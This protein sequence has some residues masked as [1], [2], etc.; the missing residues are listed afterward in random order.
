MF[1]IDTSSDDE[2]A[3]VQAAVAAYQNRTRVPADSDSGSDSAS[4]S[5]DETPWW[6]GLSN[7]QITEIAEGARFSSHTTCTEWE[8]AEGEV[9][10]E[11]RAFVYH[12]DQ[13]ITVVAHIHPASNMVF[14][15]TPGH[16]YIVGL[17]NWECE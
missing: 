10:R 13:Q 7:E 3:F 11:P 6:D 1:R 2:E 5:D 16:T 8:N 9:T 17:K 14:G 12:R 15:W 4:D